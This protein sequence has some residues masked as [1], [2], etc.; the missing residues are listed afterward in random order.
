MIGTIVDVS[1]GSC[2]NIF[3]VKKKLSEIQRVGVKKYFG[4]E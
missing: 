1:M 2:G 3:L 4:M